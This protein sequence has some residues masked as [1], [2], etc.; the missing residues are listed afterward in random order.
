MQLHY[1]Y[2]IGRVHSLENVAKWAAPE[3]DRLGITYETFFNMKEVDGKNKVLKSEEG[4][5]TKYD[6]LITIPAHKG[7]EVIEK[8]G[9]GQNGWIPTNKT[10][11]NMEGRK[12]VFVLGDTTN[13]PISKAG[14]TAHFEAETLGE[15]IAAIVKMGT[16]VREY[17]G[18]VFCF[19]EA[20]QGPRDLRD[21]RLQESARSQSADQGGALVQDGLQQALL[22]IRA[23]T[24]L[25]WRCE[26]TTETQNTEIRDEKAVMSF[27][28]ER[29]IAAGRDSLT[30]EM[31]GRLAGSAAEALDLVDKAGRAGLS[32]AIP[33][34]AEMVNNGDLERLSQLARVYHAAQDALT[35]EMIGRMA[36]TLGEGM[37]LLDR[38]NRSGFWRLVEVMERLESTGALERIA[39]SLPQLLERLELVSG[40]LS[41][42]ENAA[43]NSKAQPAKGGIGSLWHIM[44]DEKAVNS[45]QFLLNMS[46]Q[47]QEHCAKPK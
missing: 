31:V 8:N 36:E 6:L 18:K 24:P 15:N 32:K 10:K 44:T 16:P 28:L 39:T 41:C 37:S 2:P 5:E 35:D 42:L 29:V 11:L 21:V 3:F 43:K 1:T 12:N 46:E 23:R 20:R 19:I 17:D 14:S 33:A 34:I 26:M 47:M 27:E 13:I 22:D 45:L 38:V 40:M 9:L 4:T 30:D 25:T 7:M